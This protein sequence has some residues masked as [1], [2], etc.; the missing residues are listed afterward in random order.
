MKEVKE[1]AEA[2]IAKKLK[3]GKKPNIKNKN[4]INYRPKHHGDQSSRKKTFISKL[5]TKPL[6]AKIHSLICL[7]IFCGKKP[8]YGNKAR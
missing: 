7:K 8:G 5:A 4:N 1:W 6:N 2:K 3:K